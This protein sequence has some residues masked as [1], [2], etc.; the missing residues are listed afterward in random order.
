MWLPAVLAPRT[1]F[2]FGEITAKEITGYFRSGSWRTTP[3]WV[4]STASSEGSSRWTET[5]LKWLYPS[6]LHCFFNHHQEK[7]MCDLPLTE[8]GW[9]VCSTLHG[10]VPLR[11]PVKQNVTFIRIVWTEKKQKCEETTLRESDLAADE[12]LKLQKQNEEVYLWD[13][14]PHLDSF[15]DS[16]WFEYFH[17]LIRKRQSH[18]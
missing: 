13:F 14:L 2:I 8:G 17:E 11:F 1:C 9:L 7:L 15:G 5:Q 4:G 12:T 18:Q 3:S 10:S 6:V 16:S